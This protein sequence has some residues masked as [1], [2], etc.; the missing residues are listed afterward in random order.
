M[1]QSVGL[2]DRVF[3]AAETPRTMLHVAALLRFSPPP[4]PGPRYLSELADEVRA[5]VAVARPWNLKLAHPRLGPGPLQRWVVEDDID[6]EYHVRRSALPSPGDERELGALVSRL[7]GRQIDLSRPPWEM[8]LIEGLDNGGFAM[9]VKM[10]HALVDGYTGMKLLQRSL[11]TSPDDLE[12]PILFA[13]NAPARPSRDQGSKAPFVSAGT[14][15]VDALRSTRSLISATTRAV[16]PVGSADLIRPHEAPRTILNTRIG[17]SRRFATQQLD[18]DGLRMLGKR[19]G[20][21]L[22]D[23]SLCLVGGALRTYLTELG[24]LPDKPLVALVPVSTR[25][26][27]DAGGGNVFG[28]VLAS[29]GTDLAD[30]HERLAA[31]VA[32]TRAAKAQLAGMGPLSAVAYAALLVAPMLAQAGL[33]AVGAPL[34]G[35]FSFNLIVSNVPGPQEDRYFRGSRLEAMYPASLQLDAAALNITLL[36][37]AGTLNFGFSGDREAVPHLQRLAVLLGEEW[38]S[39][40]R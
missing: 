2:I 22:N 1:S 8:H 19:H 21:S 25:R 10:H 14:A 32:S 13:A 28:A 35:P 31:V 5:E 27:G 11:S 26:D 12:S 18:L 30:P 23:V 38:A 20:A 15:M 24:A 3:L 29:L 37:Y 39:M 33:A 16:M 34:P 36:S 17:R 6:L 7:H 40:S 4:N 9:F